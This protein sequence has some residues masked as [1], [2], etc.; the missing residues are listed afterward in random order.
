MN[1]S[2]KP[3]TIA[4]TFIGTVREL[5][6]TK[7]KQAWLQPNFISEVSKPLKLDEILDNQVQ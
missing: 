3:Q 5:L 2:Y 7:V 6:F 4:P 1:V